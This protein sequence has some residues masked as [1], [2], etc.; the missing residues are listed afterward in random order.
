MHR[1]AHPLYVWKIVLQAVLLPF[2]DTLVLLS[3]HMKLPNSETMSGV[4]DSSLCVDV[5]VRFHLLGLLIPER[6]KDQLT[7]SHR[8][9]A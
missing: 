3:F 6:R 7:L 5:D 1:P 2:Y 8:S 4:S 9:H